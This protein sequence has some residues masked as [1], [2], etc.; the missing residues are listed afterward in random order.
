MSRLI[1]AVLTA[2]CTLT[3]ASIA[4]PADASSS[5][6]TSKRGSDSVCC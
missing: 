4:Q 2:V 3:L 5:V 1:A 6:V